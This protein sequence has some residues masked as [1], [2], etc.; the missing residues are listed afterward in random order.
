MSGL[1]EV[2]LKDALNSAVSAV[3][4]AVLS[5]V[6]N[7]TSLT[8]IDGEQLLNLVVLTF[9]SSLVKKLASDEDGKFLGKV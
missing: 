2:N 9:V 8:S 7:L 3:I 5:Y 4:V 1:F 6:G